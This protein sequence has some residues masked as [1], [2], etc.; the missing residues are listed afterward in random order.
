MP[1]EKKPE[2]IYL[3][4]SATTRVDPRVVE[5]MLPYFT[6]EYGNPSSLHALGQRANQA[7]EQAHRMVAQILNCSPREVVFTG[8]GTES[9]NLALRGVALARRHEGCHIVTTPI[10]HHA[11]THTLEQ[12]RQT[13]GV[14]VTEVPVDEHGRVDPQAVAAALR[15]DT[16]LVS[17]MYANNEVGTIQPIA[18]IG[19]L[20]RQ[21]GIT[22]HTDAVQAGGYLPLDVEALQVDLLSLSGHK[23]H[24]PKGV[25]VLYVRR[26]TP[27]V[28]TITGGGQEDGRRSGT[29][30]IPGIVGLATA[31]R[32]A[33]S[34]RAAKNER[35]QAMRDHLISGVLESVP[36]SRLTGQPEWR[37]PGHASFTIDG[38]EA[39]ALLLALD[40]ES[41]AASSGSAC[42]SGA[43]EPSHV[44]QAMGVPRD[45]AM[46]AL[47]LSL[48]DDNEPEEIERALDVLPKVVERLRAFAFS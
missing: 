47:R 40:L 7:L 46:G 24:G 32:L 17:V 38:V 31:L 8:S 29:Q 9:D 1:A 22:F 4:H 23:F 5:A 36:G 16:I 33:Q 12:L 48:G 2:M 27:Y 37:L 6:E 3:D 10:E 14:E 20:V 34:E 15:S 18:E 26:G 19:A 42:A 28:S 11:I 30:N 43:A 25:G 21:R 45:R 44:L 13:M 41:I 39:D 35:L